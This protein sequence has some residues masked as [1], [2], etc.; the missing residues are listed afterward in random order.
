MKTTDN[1]KA[2]K[3]ISQGDSLF[4]KGKFKDA[5]KKYK[6]AQ[7]L[8]PKRQD[9]YDRLV[10]THEKSTGEWKPEDVVESV[11]YVMEKQ[12]VMNPAIKFLHQRLTPEWRAVIDKASEL[13]MCAGE[14]KEYSLIEE[15]QSFGRDAVYP[16]IYVL[17]QIKKSASSAEKG[18]DKSCETE[19]K[20]K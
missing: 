16:L 5:L 12:E 20:E 7:V 13:L 8:N 4:K 1:E 14:D 18:D 17:L 2:E 9:I 3:L 15:I 11:G 10:E 19:E 6:K